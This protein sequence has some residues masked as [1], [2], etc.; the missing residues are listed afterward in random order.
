MFKSCALS[1]CIYIISVSIVFS[2]RRFKQENQVDGISITPSIGVG[3]VVG[4]LGNVL[5]VKPVYGINIDKGISEKVNI[6]IG[7]VGGNLQGNENEPYFSEFKNDYFQIQT[8]GTLNISRY[9]ITSYNKN[10]L[11][12]KL[13]GGFGMIWFHT[14]VFDL[15]SGSLLRATS[16]NASKHTTLFQPTGVGIGEAGIYYT[17]EL[18]IPF[19]FKVDYKLSNELILNFDLGYGWVNNDKLDGT[20]PYNVLNPSIIAGV[21]SYSDT[22]NDGWINLSVGLKYIFS[23]ERSRNQRGV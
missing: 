13:Y 16:E 8:L 14:K 7:I 19:G 18:V 17:R 9:F 5:D 20:T 15:R 2:Q 23:I 21:N 6:G 10:I 1:I 12:V 3:S 11:E 22:M 4:E